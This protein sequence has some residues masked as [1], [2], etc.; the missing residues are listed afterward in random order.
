MFWKNGTYLFIVAAFILAHAAVKAQSWSFQTNPIASGDTTEIGK[1]QFVS[2]TEG[3]ISVGTGGRLLHTTNAGENW[4]MVTPFPDD[5]VWCSSDP[6]LSM[7]WPDQTH[8]WQINSIGTRFGIS[9]GVVIYQTA[10]GG[11]SWQKKVLSTKNGDFGFQIQ[12][13]DVNHG[14]L[15][16]FN[17]STQVSTFFKTSDGGS[18]WVPFNGA[19]IFYFTDVNNGWAFYGSGLDGTQ[20]PFKIL[21][22]V[23]GGTD[24]TE[25]FS[26]NSAGTY[27]AIFFSDIN[28]GWI[29]GD[30]GK[31]LKTTNGGTNWNYVTNSGINPNDRSKTVFFLNADNGWISTKDGNG[32]GV[33][34]HTT[35]GGK[36]WTRQATP[37]TSSQGGNAIF[38]IYFFDAHNG[39]LTASNK[40]ICRFTEP[41][42]IEANNNIPNEFLLCQN[43]PNPFNPSTTIDYSIKAAG[44]VKLSVFDALG[45]RV[46]VVVDEYK[47]AGSYSVK[48]DGRS[49]PSGVYLYRL[50]SGDYNASKKFIL[51]K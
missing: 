7:S 6:A 23:N 40:K 20:P 28:N 45:K 38:N 49:L 21:H 10:D 13:V 9:Y 47:S 30:Q 26:D 36:S 43:Y 11:K 31:V 39:W 12:F 3:W 17:F 32:Y 19:G 42:G 37:L 16:C 34:Q 35:D 14:W 33:I 8:G 51:M 41:T 15:L 44:N 5:T 25:Q 1:V 18:N 50:E 29:V 27:N 48:F 24:W 2:P 46:A 4:T 22:T